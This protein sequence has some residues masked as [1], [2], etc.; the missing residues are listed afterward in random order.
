[1]G[2]LVRTVVERDDLLSQAV[3]FGLSGVASAGAYTATIVALVEWGGWH[4]AL[5]TTA[6]FTAG[7]VISYVLNSWFTFNRRLQGR[8]FGRFWLVTLIGWGINVGIVEGAQWVGLHYGFGIF[9]S[10]VVAPAFNF[11]AHRYWTFAGMTDPSA[12]E[13]VEDPAH[14]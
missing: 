2:N 4:T 5:A 9:G 14:R 11:L 8:A 13:P 6:G 7:T 10:L 12:A 3:K 1:M